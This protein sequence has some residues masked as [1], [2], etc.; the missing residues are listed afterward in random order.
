MITRRRFLN[1]VTAVGM[2]SAIGLLPARTAAEPPPETRKLRIVREASICYAPIYVAEELLGAEG[3]TDV[4]YVPIEAGLGPG[5]MLG[6]GKADVGIDAVP[7]VVMNLDA[8]DPILILA[9]VHVGCYE[10]FGTDQVRAVRDLKGRT[11]AVSE[12]RNDQHAFVA[13]MLSQVG[14]DP[15]RDVRWVTH[16]APEAM[17]LLAEKKIDAFLGFPPEPQELRAKKVGHV[18][19]DIRTDRPWSQYFCCVAVANRAFVR[20]H[21]VAAKRAL[22]AILK[23]NAI[24]ALEPERVARLL[25]DKG[26]ATQREYVQQT[27]KEIPYAAWREYNAADSVRF[28]ALRLNEAGMIKAS[29]SKILSEGT[30]WRFF[31]ELKKELKG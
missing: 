12:L 2:V 19:V 6:A 1:G 8:G 11:I 27:L 15:R 25:V 9:G 14:L 5:R 13:S 3:F 22:R 24:C 4:H 20:K 10:L 23:A 28:Y 17:K 16:P 29:P 30:D 31:N 21:P 7:P 18:L 26:Y